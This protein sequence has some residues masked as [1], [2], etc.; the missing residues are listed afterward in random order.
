MPVVGLCFSFMHFCLQVALKIVDKSRIPEEF[1]KKM[2]REIAINKS[3]R[4]R[5]VLRFY[6]VGACWGL[7]Q[8]FDLVF[9]YL[10]WYLSTKSV[11]HCCY[12]DIAAM[13]GYFHVVLLLSV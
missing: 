11:V 3:L 2:Y 13:L 9:V 8:K 6:Q 12:V 10:F 1:V 4:H 5:H 7:F